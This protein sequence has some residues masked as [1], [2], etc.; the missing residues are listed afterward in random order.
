MNIFHKLRWHL[1]LSYTI[2]ILVIFDYCWL[3]YPKIG[4]QPAPKPGI[5]NSGWAQSPGVEV[6]NRGLSAWDRLENYVLDVIGT[7]ADDKRIL[8]WDVYNEP[9]NSA[10]GIKSLS[11]L[12]AVFEWA[13][14][15]NPSQPLSAGIWF[16]N[17]KLN[18]FQLNSSD[19]ITFHNY[20]SAENLQRQI[21]ELKTL[22][23]PLICTEWLARTRGCLVST[24]LPV[25]AQEKVGCLNWGL[26]AGI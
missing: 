2:V 7:F 20:Y 21:M 19:V 18:E 11:F 26:V 4:T 5:H 9:G 3:S 17:R 25:F 13:H 10:N 15:A 8:L 23:R 6:V 1:T 22:E 14:S 16:K 12:E 24:N